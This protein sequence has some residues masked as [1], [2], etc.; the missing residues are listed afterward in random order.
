[1][2]EKRGHWLL[3]ALALALYAP[4]LGNGLT[5][6][7]DPTFTTA[8]PFVTKGLSGALDAFTR[9]YDGAY[10]PLTHALL[11]LVGA[12][13]P[14]NPLPYHLAAWLLFG[15]SVLV[16][17]AA[18]SAFGVS[19]LT[20]LVATAL[21]L[22]H[23]FRVESVA[24]V[25]NLKDPLSLLGAAL[26]FALYAR[27]R[28]VASAVVFT[29][30]LLAKASVAPL[31]LFVLAL[32]W[33]RAPGTRAL[34]SSLKWL[35]PALVLGVVAVQV[36]RAYLPALR[37]S[38][39]WVTPLFTP[40]WYLGH[41]LWPAGPRV[42]YAWSEPVGL[43]PFLL[44]GLWLALGGAVVVGLSRRG[45]GPSRTF[46]VGVL[47]FLVPLLPFSG[48]VPQ[49]HVVAERY[50]L[51]PSLVIA[52]G[53]GAA[54]VAVGRAGVGVALALVA[55]LAVPTLARQREWRDSLSLWTSNVAL[56]PTSRVA[57][58]NLAGALG[59]ASRFA[60][61]YRELL[62]LRDLDASWPG[63]DCFIAMARAGK[64]Q[65]EPS[66]SAAELP[67]LCRLPASE[68]WT[69]AAPIIARKDAAAVLVLDELAF[70]KDRAKAAAAAAAFAIEKEDFERAFA[71][72][73]QAR[74]WDST[75][76][77]TLVTQVIAL[78]KLKRLD[79]A[80]ALTATPVTDPRVAARLLGL[81]AA[82]LN[83]QGRYAEA[84]QLLQQSA[85]ALRQLGDG[86]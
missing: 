85:E 45:G 23:P 74:L 50:T 63:L 30:G 46:A 62:A 13:A 32:E 56:E 25:A 16:L 69:A 43:W 7:D 6:W 11:T 37:E 5:N 83:E 1:M 12:R 84:E 20:A 47:A 61:A 55:T 17:P 78:L 70:G 27:A 76:E 77:R 60:D 51:Y 8:S 38:T 64:E 66:F 3:F 86:R 29:L 18:L 33:R 67:A 10:S 4:S 54:L 58:L 15:L 82:I 72:A 2:L 53:L 81:R 42:V 34:V 59:G 48:L 71:L 80:R 39:T 52:L 24:W 28:P 35:V 41:V 73:T 40:L 79:E 14:E 44:I 22:V 75:L 21:W 57:R 19:R 49:V 36:H 65:L 26:A 68:R 31:A 9:P